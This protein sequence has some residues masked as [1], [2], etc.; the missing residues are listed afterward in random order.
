[1]FVLYLTFRLIMP[2]TPLSAQSDPLTPTQLTHKPNT[3]VLVGQTGRLSFVKVPMAT[4][5]LACVLHTSL[6]RGHGEL[7]KCT[8]VWLVAWVK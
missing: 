7:D 4:V 2:R 3:E 5:R 6:C 8:S 1:M